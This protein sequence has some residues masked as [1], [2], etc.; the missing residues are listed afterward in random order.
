MIIKSIYQKQEIHNQLI[1][2]LQVND[3]AVSFKKAIVH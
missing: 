2:Q 3:S 1:L